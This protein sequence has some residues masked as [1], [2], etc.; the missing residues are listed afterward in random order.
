MKEWG[1]EL[2]PL[3]P[4]LFS[5]FFSP[6]MFLM[7]VPPSEGTALGT[8]EAVGKDGCYVG[9]DFHSVRHEDFN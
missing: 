2:S 6:L 5:S 8:A 1:R 4:P 9:A 7:L 3:S